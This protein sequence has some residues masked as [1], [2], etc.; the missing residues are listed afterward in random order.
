MA[1]GTIFEL[2]RRSHILALCQN[3]IFMTALKRFVLIM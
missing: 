2:Q 1:R 3:L